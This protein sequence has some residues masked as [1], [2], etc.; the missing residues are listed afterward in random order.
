MIIESNNKFDSI[1][2]ITHINELMTQ[3]I[4][5]QY[6]KNTKNNPIEL[7]ILIPQLTN[8]N[9][10]KFEMTK[11]DQKIISKLLEKEKAKEKY[12]DSIAKGDYG[13]ISYNKENE[14]I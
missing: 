14:T 8:C 9:I 3:T 2:I 11:G 1:D 7:E 4:V 5:T 6:F 13:F 12:N 10:T